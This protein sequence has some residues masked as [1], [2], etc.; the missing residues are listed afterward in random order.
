MAATAFDVD[1]HTAQV[2]AS[3][4]D[5]FGVETKAEVVKCAIGL[6]RLVAEYADDDHTVLLVGK[7]DKALKLKLAV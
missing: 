2:I 3:L 4:R 1:D 7:D 5:V 6:A